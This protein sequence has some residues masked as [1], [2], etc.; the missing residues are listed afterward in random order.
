M[1]K[2]ETLIELISLNKKLYS[3]RDLEKKTFAYSLTHSKTSYQ[4]DNIQNN[5]KPIPYIQYYK[6][7]CKSFSVIID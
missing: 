1:I 6:T 5:E 7:S 4:I 2:L 3:K